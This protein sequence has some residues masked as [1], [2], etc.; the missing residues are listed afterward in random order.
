M[1]I[2][3]CSITKSDW[4]YYLQPKMEK[5]CIV[6]FQSCFCWLYIACTSLA[7]NNIINLI[8]VLTI[9]WC[10]C[11]QSSYLKC[12][13]K[14]YWINIVQDIYFLYLFSWHLFLCM[15]T[16]Y[17]QCHTYWYINYYVFIVTSVNG[18]FSTFL[19]EALVQF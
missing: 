5:L 7:A 3:R 1:D 13:L 12:F 4:L 10:P 16:Y 8:L 17:W 19:K 15:F 9:W 2:T 14:V 6:S 18:E 11:V